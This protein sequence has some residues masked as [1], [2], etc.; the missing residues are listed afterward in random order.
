MER[1]RLGNTL[2]KGILIFIA[3]IAPV[4][5]A[6][7]AGDPVETS[8]AVEKRISTD[9]RARVIVR[10]RTTE[11]AA[12]DAQVGTEQDLERRRDIATRQQRIREQLRGTNHNVRREFQSL[13]YTVVEVDAA[14]LARLQRATGDVAQIA[15]DLLFAPTLA[16]SIPQIEADVAHAQGFIGSGSVIAI[17]DTGVDSA[18]PFLA[19]RVIDEACFADREDPTDPGS[20]PNGSNQQFGAGAGVPCAYSPNTCLHGTHVAG[21][22]AGSG[23]TPG[24]APGANLFA[25]QVFHRSTA[26]SVS[27]SFPCAR[28]FTSDITAALEYVY[29]RRTVH[30]LASINM[31]L[32]G[33][34]ALTP[35]DASIPAMAAV[36]NNLKAAG[37][38]TVIASG[39]GSNR[40]LIS[41]PACIAAAIAVGA[42]DS[43]DGVASFSNV[44]TGLDLFAPGVSIVS[45]VPG[46][47][48]ATFSGTS[49]ATPHVAGAWAVMR[50]ANPLASVDQV[51]TSLADTGKP[52]FDGR[53]GGSVTK[54]RIRLGAALGIESPAPILLSV[55]PASISA[56]TSGATITAYGSAFG[57]ASVVRI[58]GAPRPTAYV[59]DT[60]LRAQVTAADLETQATSFAITVVTP[61]PGGGTSAVVPIV[62]THPVLSVDRTTAGTGV[63]VTLTLTNGTGIALD[64]LA[65]AQVGDGNSSYVKWTYVGAGNTTFVWTVNMPSTPGTYEFR[66]FADGGYTRAATSQPI[67]VTSATPPPPPPPPPPVD[68]PALS[69]SATAV[70]TGVPVT[71]TLTNGSGV[72][73]DW[74]ALAQVGA[75][76]STYLKWTYVGAGN[77]TFVWTVNMPST[78]GAYEFRLF[79]A[80][81][82]TRTATS[83]T[84]T[85]TSATPPPPPPPPPPVDPPALSL[86]ATAVNTGVAVTVTLTNGSGV[87]N[88]WLALARVGDGNS[89]Y[90]NWTYVGAGN[91][92]FVWTVNMP[93]TPGTYEFRLF[94]AGGY[95]RTATSATITVTSPPPPPP[96]PTPL[97]PT[98]SVNTTVAT[99]GMPVTVTLI[100]GSGVA[101]DWL[102]LARVGAPATSYLSWTYVGAGNTTFV[103][104]ANMPSTPGDYEF[105]LFA[106]NGYGLVTTSLPIQVGP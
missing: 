7:G 96:P 54:P 55:S 57:R 20:C 76:N 66:L 39:N 23:D 49:M 14:G 90:L 29:T 4:L 100:N 97:P 48:F 50:Q 22:A 82:Y 58:N 12:T 56:R 53:T 70:N 2:R 6:Q 105:R 85:V 102:A 60:E 67:T 77:T 80:G 94:S 8:Q 62:V 59:S 92:T 65:L 95:S 83:A 71:V 40:T 17:V 3:L 47:G 69:L 98:L 31:S 46:G 28:A 106:Q 101:S 27:E 16:R 42:V 52:I 32:G 63:P 15:E 13:P 87:S 104:T 21:I 51:L 45:S 75:G 9:G 26:C 43:D 68:P 18:H 35:C 78:A 11:P 79:S 64:W 37:I 93:S 25:L 10:L 84:I 74:L 99:P 91:T 5:T 88:D 34:T 41:L 36:I 1:T 72:S 44:A 61:P 81:G 86:S 30:N 24:V 38:A 19:G 73:S 89:S 103:W 33:S